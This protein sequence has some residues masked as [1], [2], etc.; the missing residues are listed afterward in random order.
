MKIN[1]KL[2]AE[3]LEGRRDLETR[4]VLQLLQ[5]RLPPTRLRRS[6]AGRAAEAAI[7]AGIAGKFNI[8][9]EYRGKV[10]DLRDF[11]HLLRL[12]LARRFEIQDK[13]IGQGDSVTLHGSIP[14]KVLRVEDTF[15][16]LL[17]LSGGRGRYAP[18]S[19]VTKP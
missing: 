10:A 9:N 14:A 11:L 7:L 3:F 15:Y 17:K 18:P 8:P 1:P 16:L 5:E 6:Q 2:I 12:H 4:A 13:D 19:V